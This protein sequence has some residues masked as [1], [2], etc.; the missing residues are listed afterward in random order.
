MNSRSP[1]LLLPQQQ[2]SG[3]PLE[4]KLEYNRLA[5]GLPIRERQRLV[6]H[7]PEFRRVSVIVPLWNE[8]PLVEAL[9]ER[10]QTICA[11][12]DVA[13]EFIM[14]NDGSTDQTTALLESALPALG[15]WKLISLSR[16]FGQQAA[17]R[18]GL[19]HADGDA[20]VFIDGDLQD[21][22]EL[23]PELVRQWRQGAGVVVAC[24]RSRKERGWRR[25]AFDLFHRTFAWLTDSIMP[26]NSGMF[27]LADRAAVDHMRHLP[28]CCLFMPA[29]RSWVGFKQ[30]IVWYDRDDRQGGDIKQSF[31]R[32]VNYAWDGVTSF[33]EKPLRAITVLGL[34][35]FLSTC[36]FAVLLIA[37]K[38]LQLF[39]LL[40]GLRVPGFTTLAVSVLGIGGLQLL[41]IGILG[42]Y[43][44]RI[45]REVKRRPSYIVDSIKSSD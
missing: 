45:Y 34:V 32:L 15:C 19:D 26:P 31:P 17:Y 39:G 14:V 4:A 23:I 11:S 37:A 18:A 3:H 33:S 1:A 24:R 35:L 2:R 36:F 9:V 8:A 41:C 13:Y 21:P 10:L 25:L 43:I 40:E 42:E 22:P 29:I 38:I 27:G 5:G 12:P 20:V 28:E 16:N 44:A 7:K 30:S 6:V